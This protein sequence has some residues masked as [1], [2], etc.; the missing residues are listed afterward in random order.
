VAWFKSLDFGKRQIDA[1]LLEGWIEPLDAQA[2][3]E[4]IVLCEVMVGNGW[5]SAARLFQVADLQTSP[6]LAPLRGRADLQSSAPNRPIAGKARTLTRH[7]P[8]VIST[9]ALCSGSAW[10]VGHPEVGRWGTRGQ[11]SLGEIG[12]LSDRAIMSLIKA[13]DH[14]RREVTKQIQNQVYVVGGIR[15]KFAYWI[16]CVQRPAR[17]QCIDTSRSVA[18]VT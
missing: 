3:S 14:S 18:S 11:A 16:A 13:A 5:L 10:M 8:A 2:Q 9:A 12:R 1:P 15:A 7:P 4:R 6:D 17:R